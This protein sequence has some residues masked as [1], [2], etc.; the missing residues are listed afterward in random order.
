MSIEF[1]KITK[2]NLTDVLKLKVKFEQKTF[3]IPNVYSIAE[4]KVY[5]N[6]NPNAV[7]WN[8]ELIGFLMYGTNPEKDEDVW[9]IRLMIDEKFQGRGYGR[10]TMVKIIETLKKI[11][12]PPAIFLSFEPENNI[13][14]SL[15]HSL[16][17]KDTGEILFGELVHRLDLKTKLNK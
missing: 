6:F 17:F 2:D 9:I 13:A 16:G 15:Y 10:Q 14:R 12:D 4:S 7:Y 11:Y 5:E 8:E 1:K 3:V